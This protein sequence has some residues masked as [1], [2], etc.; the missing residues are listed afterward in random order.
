MIKEEFNFEEYNNALHRT[1]RICM[2]IMIVLL[3][4]A[5]FL[6]SAATGAKIEW[7]SFFKAIVPVLIVYIPS[8]IVEYLIYVPLLGPGA[9]YLA[10]TTGNITNLKLPCAFNARDMAHAETGSRENEIIATLSVAT[11]SLVTMLVIF[12]GVLAIIPLTPVLENPHTETGIR[13]RASRTLRSPGLP[14]LQKESEDYGVAALLHGA[15]LHHYPGSN[16]HD[17]L[18]AH[19]LRHPRNGLCLDSLQKEYPQIEGV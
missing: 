2:A 18:H 13:Q 7:A 9:S 6:V 12:I 16:Q 11:S 1:G 14:V 3:L 4:S 15:S 8:C 5:P 17:Q 10:F 19:R